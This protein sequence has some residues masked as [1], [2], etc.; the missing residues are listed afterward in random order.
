MPKPCSTTHE[1]CERV[2]RDLPILGRAVRLNV[3]LRRVGC[4]DCG[5]RME[6]VSWLDRYCSGKLISPVLAGSF[7]V[8]YTYVMK[9]FF[10]LYD[11]FPWKSIR[12]DA[13]SGNIW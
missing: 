1:Y 6:A 13:D 7:Q 2:I 5:K 8:L 3:L 10:G 9:L 11:G 4:R 12:R